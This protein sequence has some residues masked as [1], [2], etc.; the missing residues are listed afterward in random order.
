MIAR[1]KMSQNEWT[2]TEI[3]AWQSWPTSHPFPA[4]VVPV[5]E[6]K[7]PWLASADLPPRRSA[8]LARLQAA[9]PAAVDAGNASAI[10][11]LKRRRETRK[12]AKRG[13][14]C[15]VLVAPRTGGGTVVK[16]YGVNAAGAGAALRSVLGANA[17]VVSGGRVSRSALLG[18]GDQSAALDAETM[19]NL[20]SAELISQLRAILAQC[21]PTAGICCN[22]LSRAFERDFGSALVETLFGDFESL[23]AL[24]RAPQLKD[25]VKLVDQPG[26]P[27]LAVCLNEKP[28]DALL[29]SLGLE[30]Y[31]TVLNREDVSVAT[32]KLMTEDV[33]S[34][35]VFSAFFFFLKDAPARKPPPRSRTN[36][37]A[38]PPRRT[39]PTSG[40]PKDRAS[41]FW[42]GPSTSSEPPALNKNKQIVSEPRRAR[43]TSR[44]PPGSR[45]RHRR[46]APANPREPPSPTRPL[47]L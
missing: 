26:R 38:A 3:R 32:L 16:A 36:A 37:A 15:R 28:V 19:A 43:A 35:R 4:Q 24:L 17:A 1:P 31:A 34:P 9:V 40:F 12:R 14:H 11:K 2:S 41:N 42:P 27:D 6:P 23:A 8:P 18:A 10:Q 39:S 46:R 13:D 21:D 44:A 20:G 30:R 5:D 22:H 25:V 47:L 45:P 7:L 33:R 29:A